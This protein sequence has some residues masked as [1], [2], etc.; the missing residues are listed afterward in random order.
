VTPDNDTPKSAAEG[1]ESSGGSKVVGVSLHRCGHVYHYLTDLDLKRGTRVLV[2]SEVGSCLAT[3]ECECRPADKTIDVAQL[4]PIVR[5]AD[6]RDLEREAENRELE[7]EAHRVCQEKIRE[8]KLEMKL[9][10]VEYTF[11]RRKAIFNF[12]SEGRVDFRELVRELAAIV[13]VRVEMRHIGAHDETKI[14]GGVGPCGRQLCCASWV[15]DFEAI[16]LKMAREQ[17]LALNPSRLAGMCGRLKCCLRYEYATYVELKRNLPAMG[18]TVDSIHGGGKVIGQDLLKQTVTIQ[19]SEDN[20]VVQA[21]LDDLL[22][23]R[24]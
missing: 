9:A 23:K 1:P 11:D 5:V 24:P 10:G 14:C 16:T 13:H 2:E 15:R 20:E 17:N 7:R 18:T 12:L 4:H 19:R 22:E 21:T 6:E 3:V 8:H